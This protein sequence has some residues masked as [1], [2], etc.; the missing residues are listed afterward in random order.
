MFIEAR[1]TKGYPLAQY[2]LKMYRRAIEKL[3][4]LSGVYRMQIKL[5]ALVDAYLYFD[6]FSQLNGAYRMS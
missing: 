3:K 2:M 6:Q 1:V 5:S 4:L